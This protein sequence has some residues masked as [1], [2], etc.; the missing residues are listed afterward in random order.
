MF[1]LYWRFSEKGY[2]FKIEGLKVTQGH[3]GYWPLTREFC[4]SLGHVCLDVAFRAR[5]S[6][7]VCIYVGL[8]MDTLPLRVF[9]LVVIFI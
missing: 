3:V 8:K 4:F 9:L 6:T 2:H 5:I 7:V 1:T